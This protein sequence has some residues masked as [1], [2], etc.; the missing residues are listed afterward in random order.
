VD[1]RKSR[2]AAGL[3]GIFIGALG[4]H[5]FYLGRT[6]R[7]V[8]QLLLTVFTCGYGAIITWPWALIESIML[9]A[10]ST[11]VDGRG[12]PLRD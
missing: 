8:I 9:F 5:N 10:G 7:G 4:I 12:E 1:T 3:I 2:L 11:N 6:A